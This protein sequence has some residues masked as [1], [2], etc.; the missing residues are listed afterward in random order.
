MASMINVGLTS[1][2]SSWI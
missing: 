1:P 2:W